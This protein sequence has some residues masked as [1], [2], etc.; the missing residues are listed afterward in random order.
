MSHP[1]RWWPS[2][3]LTFLSSRLLEPPFGI[4]CVQYVGESTARRPPPHS[5]SFGPTAATTYILQLLL[6]LAAGK[7]YPNRRWRQPT[8]VFN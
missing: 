8:H 3:L 1:C 5:Q 4:V 6:A 7:I 2:E